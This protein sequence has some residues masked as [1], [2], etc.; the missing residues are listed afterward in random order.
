MYAHELYAVPPG[1]SGALLE[2]LEGE[3]RAAVEATGLEA[4]GA[5]DVAMVGGREVVVLW[6]I[7][8][9]ATWTAFE[10][11]WAADGALAGWGRTL[12]SLGAT[13]HRQLMVDAPLSPLRTGRQPQASDRRPL[14]EV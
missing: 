8:D 2:A 10:Q 9:W 12:R 6:A 14:E 5:Y 4:V 13:F 7:P 11:A 1:T 3:G